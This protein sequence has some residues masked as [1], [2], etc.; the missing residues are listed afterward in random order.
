[1]EPATG[2]GTLSQMETSIVGLK[3][4]GYVIFRTS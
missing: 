1:L 2:T 4:E 3:Q